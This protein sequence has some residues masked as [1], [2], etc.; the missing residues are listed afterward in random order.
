MKPLPIDKK[1]EPTD[2]S[3]LE[4]EDR[5]KALL[6]MRDGV[7]QATQ[8][9][10]TGVAYRQFCISVTKG[11]EFKPR[12]VWNTLNPRMQDHFKHSKSTLDLINK[13]IADDQDEDDIFQLDDDDQKGVYDESE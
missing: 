1:I 8:K 7:D 5:V 4:S 9:A 11:I 13:L 6:W 10:I 12:A 2:W 3:D